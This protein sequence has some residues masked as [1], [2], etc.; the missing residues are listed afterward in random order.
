MDFAQIATLA[1]NVGVG[2]ALAVWF[3]FQGTKREDR[4][5]D[6]ISELEAFQKQQLLALV[7]RNAELLGQNQNV[8][9]RCITTMDRWESH[10]DAID[11]AC[12]ESSSR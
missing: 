1:A 10:L 6:R 12:R 4:F 8:L 7:E 9:E 5:N 2:S 11:K 3:V